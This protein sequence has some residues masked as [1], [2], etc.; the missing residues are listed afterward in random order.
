M[1]N[2]LK[3]SVA[4]SLETLR[5]PSYEEIPEIGLYL[6][7]TVR[8]ISE[9]L[10]SL[11]NV[12]ITS[13]MVGNYVKQGLIES[14]QKKCYSR[15][16]IAY[17]LFIAVAKTVL[18]LEDVELLISIQKKSY[19]SRTA[20]EYFVREFQNVMNFVFGITDKLEKVGKEQ[21]DEKTM[22]RN[23]IFAVSYKI[24]LDKCFDE[25]HRQMK[26]ENSREE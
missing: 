11:S 22:L 25:I 3:A 20:Y 15:D 10:S 1:D 24:Y 18:S 19:D 13:N 9:C 7:Q 8:Y 2:N 6:E 17:L 23:T 14:P 4:E 5:L 16:Q 12:T 21:S 26:G